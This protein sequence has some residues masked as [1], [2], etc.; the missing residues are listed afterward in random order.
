MGQD[1]ST[2]R[3]V[4]SLL[5][6]VLACSLV[7]LAALGGGRI[8][9]GTDA[10]SAAV[11][12]PATAV[13]CDHAQ[14]HQAAEEGAETPEPRMAVCFDPH[15]P[16]PPE[17]MDLIRGGLPYDELDYQLSSNVWANNGTPYT[18]TWSFVPD[19]TSLPHYL[20]SQPRAPSELF[21]RMDQRFG[22]NRALWISLFEQCFDR[23]GE[24]TGVTFV[25]VTSPG[26]PWDDGSAFPSIGGTSTRGHIRIGMRPLDNAGGVLAFNY[27]P[28]YSDMVL[29]AAESWQGSTFNY[30]FLRNVVMHE[31]GHGLGMNHCCPQ[32]NSKLLEPAYSSQYDGPQHDDVRAIH[33]LHGDFYEPNDNTVNATNLGTLGAGQSYNPSVVPGT[34]FPFASRTSID[35]GADQDIFSF[36]TTGPISLNVSVTPVGHTYLSGPQLSGGCSAGSSVNS[37]TAAALAVQVYGPNA[38]ILKATAASNPAGMA[39]TIQNLQL[40]QPGVY[41][42]RV[43]ATTATGPQFYHL[44][45][46]AAVGSTCPTFTQHPVNTEVCLFDGFTLYSQASGDPV[47]TYQW[48]R[49]GQNIPGATGPNYL[50]FLATTEHAGTYDVVATNACGMMTSQSAVVTIQTA[51]AMTTHPE[52]QTVAPGS[53][54]SLIAA[55]SGVPAP[56]FRWFK[57]T[58]QIPGGTS[59]TLQFQSV[60]P[61]DAGDYRAEAFNSCGTMLS[62]IATLTVG[63]ACYA[64]CDGSTTPPILNVEDF[65]CFINRFAEAQGLPHEQ[66]LTHYANCDQSTTPPVLNVE[67]FTCFINKFAQGCP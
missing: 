39:E 34:Q 27:F 13:T 7:V 48:R 36:T 33:H 28:T 30:R 12:G 23:W 60:S 47:P 9:E 56:Q 61:G 6:G 40:T 45:V 59:G 31:M 42:V 41:Y 20:Q 4:R 18:L 46:S 66:Q 52:S 2:G 57:G 11:A 44:Q 58:Q 3:D 32:N 62:N 17:V 10:P 51:P 25:R 67:D 43:Y 63:T 35:R 26:N 29:D 55:A 37:L 38:L 24:L 53:P 49:N 54:V 16:P 8:G 50:V 64:N 5:A 14:C 19:G 15:N 1:R 65:T 21:S 22:G